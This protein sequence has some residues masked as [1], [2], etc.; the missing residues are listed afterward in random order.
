MGPAEI[1][2]CI[3]TFQRPQLLDKLLQ[4]LDSLNPRTPSFRV[5]VVDNDASG[6]ARETVTARAATTGYALEYDIEPEQNIAL[7][8][9]RSLR[10]L[11]AGWVAFIDDDEVPDPDWLLNLHATAAACQ[12]DA[13]F[14]PVLPDWPEEVP[15]WIR[16]N[17]VHNR[18]RHT[19]GD[20]VPPE[21]TRTG[22]VLVRAKLLMQYEEPFDRAYG[23]TGGS[24]SDLFKR[25]AACGARYVWCDEAAVKEHVMPERTRPGWLLRRYYRGGHN[26]IRQLL[27]NYRGARFLPFFLITLPRALGL[28]LLGAVGG[29]LLWPFD[30]ARAFGIYCRAAGQVGQIAAFTSFDYAEYRS[31]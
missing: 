17:P 24:D 4:G 12:A 2:V 27:P 25:L 26:H 20:P 18:Q 19:T 10:G 8:R 7:A 14:G 9:N 11:E 29:T 16:A 30:R 15:D 13:V 31:R 1:Q 6:S 22:N 23:L 28:L 5:Q 3:C 21:Q